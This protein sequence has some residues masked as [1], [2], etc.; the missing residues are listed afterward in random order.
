[1]E[2]TTNS[3]KSMAPQNIAVIGSS[4]AIGSALMQQLAAIHP[5][6]TIYTCLLYTS[7]AADE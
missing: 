4:G 2:Q 1:M 6:A 5:D 7:D 3:Y